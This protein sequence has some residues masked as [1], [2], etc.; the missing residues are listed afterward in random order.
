M[1]RE[2]S[3]AGPLGVYLCRKKT[4]G[5]DGTRRLRVGTEYHWY[6]LAHQ[7]VRKLDANNY[8]TAMTGL[9]YKLAHKRADKGT[10]SASSRGQRRRLIEILREMIAHLEMDLEPSAA[11]P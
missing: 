2:K 5:G 9:K 1:E 11:V 10:W 6:I 4:T 7:T 8:T 3:G